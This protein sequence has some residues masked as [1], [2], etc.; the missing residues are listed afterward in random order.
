[1]IV[2]YSVTFKSQL[3]FKQKFV[4]NLLSQAAKLL[5]LKK[6]QEVSV[7]IVGNKQIQTLNKKF[8]HQD[9]V[10]DVLSFNQKEGEKI[11]KIKELNNYLGEIFIC[12]P[13]LAR[14]ARR[15]GN[16]AK[17]EFTLLLVHGLLHLLGYDDQTAL[18]DKKMKRIQDKII[19]NLHAQF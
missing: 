15:Y 6:G 16:T 7:I 12:Y 4:E 10:T 8:R 18:A 14:Q 11:I 5:N 1:M 17:E 19:S 3:P 13:Q 9:K 2:N